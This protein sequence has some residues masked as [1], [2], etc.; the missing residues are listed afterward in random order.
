MTNGSIVNTGGA[1]QLIL[2]GAGNTLTATGANTISA[3]V[4]L[5]TAA[6]L[7]R[8]FA[9]TG[10]ADSLTISGVLSE[11][12]AT[13]SLSKTLAGTLVLSGTNTYTGTTTLS[14]GT[15]A[16][17]NDSA[18]GTG[19]LSVTGAATLRPDGADRSLSNAVTL[20]NNLTV[21]GSYDLAIGGTLTNSGG[22]R[23]L[24]NSLDPG[25]T[26]TLANVNL[27]TSATVRTLTVAGAGDTTIAGA[28]ANGGAGAGSLVKSG[29]GT[30]VL[31]GTNTYTGTTTISDGTLLLDGTHTAGA[32]GD[33]QVNVNGTLGGIG[34][35][36]R[37]VSMGGGIL[38][39]G[40]AGVGSLATGNVDFL[41]AGSILSIDIDGATADLLAIVGDLRLDAGM[42]LDFNVVAEPTAP[43]YTIATYTGAIVGASG[44]FDTELDTPS[45]YEV[46]YRTNSIELALIPEPSTLAMGI[47]ALVTWAGFASRRRVFR[48]RSR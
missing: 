22:N 31:S 8:T 18:L 7:T 46:R 11:G 9:L 2:S 14:A 43:I 32:G 25:D 34:T 12:S 44:Q 16:V 40:D 26:L 36:N 39:P 45:G 42:I 41:T 29:T 15:L 10:A 47:A 30:L 13:A 21:S 23:T 28:I 27:T 24:T 33:Y 1:A 20:G 3:D 35:T 17:G 6:P 5:N 4:Q 48:R 37:D 19:V 38:A